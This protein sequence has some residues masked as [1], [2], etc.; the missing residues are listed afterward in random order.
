MTARYLDY[1]TGADA[2]D[3]AQAA[4]DY[5]ARECETRDTVLVLDTL[6]G[7]AYPLTVYRRAGS[8]GF[9]GTAGTPV[10]NYG[11]RDFL[12]GYI[13][14][15]LWADA[16]INDDGEHDDN[17]PEPAGAE[18]DR[19]TAEAGAWFIANRA[20]IDAAADCSGYSYARAG[21]DYWLTRNG[22]GAGFWD[23]DELPGDVAARLT[24]A[25]E[26]AGT[27]YLYVGDDGNTYFCRG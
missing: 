21:H 5:A 20:D 23:R 17:A 15:A 6:F 8:E 13:E 22:H 9:N 4:A 14:C 12:A 26:R 1:T 2:G 18:L 25:A 19:M 3:T 24:A 16:P 10:R 27:V 7:C 11:W